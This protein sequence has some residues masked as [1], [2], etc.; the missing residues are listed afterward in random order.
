MDLS[1]VRDL[2]LALLG[3]VLT[4]LGTF[5]IRRYLPLLRGR[6]ELNLLREL[7]T[8]AVLAVEQIAQSRGLAS[9]QKKELA[10]FMVQEG[11]RRLGVEVSDEELEAAIESAVRIWTRA[12]ALAA[13]EGE[14]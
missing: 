13:P 3:F 4:A 14:G 9:H 12:E 1:L 10:R 6:A 5:L 8:M 7:A 11:L 2:A